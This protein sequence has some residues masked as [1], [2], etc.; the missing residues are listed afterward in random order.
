MD[1]S[2]PSWKITIREMLLKRAIWRGTNWMASFRE[3]QSNFI[4]MVRA[5]TDPS[6]LLIHK[7]IESS[8]HLKYRFRYIRLQISTAQVVIVM[9][10]QQNYQSK[11]TRYKW[12]TTIEAAS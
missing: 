6:G 11:V 7:Q 1:K 5:W 4:A 12:P 3:Q 8:D 10:N 9:Q 2:R